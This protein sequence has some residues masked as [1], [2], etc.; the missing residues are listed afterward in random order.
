MR[1][2]IRDV[3]VITLDEKD[4]ILHNVEIAIEGKDVLAV[5]Q[6]SSGFV[7]DEVIDCREHVALPGFFDSHTH[8]AMTLERGWAEDLPINR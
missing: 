7:S 6:A 4:R 8:A 1:S 2:L 5:G 3:T